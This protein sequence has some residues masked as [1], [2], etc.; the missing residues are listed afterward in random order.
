[1]LESDAE[2]VSTF[3][4]AVVQDVPAGEHRFT[5]N[6]AGVAPHSETVSVPETSEAEGPTRAGVDGEVPLVAR[7]TPLVSKSIPLEPI[8][9]SPTSPSRTT[10]LVDCTTPRSPNPTLCTSTAAARIRRRSGTATTR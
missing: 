8:V 4:S 3:S 6:G 10:S 9:T 5:V 2:A 7:E 1:M